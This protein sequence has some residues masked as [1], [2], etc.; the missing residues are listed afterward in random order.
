MVGRI[1]EIE[2]AARGL[3]RDGAY[4]DAGRVWISTERAAKRQPAGM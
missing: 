1:W 2:A 4:W 3:A